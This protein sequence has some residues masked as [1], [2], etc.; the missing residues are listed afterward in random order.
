[1]GVLIVCAFLSALKPLAVGGLAIAPQ[2]PYRRNNKQ[3]LSLHQSPCLT[4]AGT[5][6]KA[7]SWK[8]FTLTY[9]GGQ[10]SMSG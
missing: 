6:G 2:T 9:S 5:Q 1:M 8:T 4:N 3:S 10:E 7:A